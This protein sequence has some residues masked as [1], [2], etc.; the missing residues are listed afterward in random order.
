MEITPTRRTTC[1]ECATGGKLKFLP[2]ADHHLVI[3]VELCAHEHNSVTFIQN[4]VGVT[5]HDC[6]STT[7]L[8]IEGAN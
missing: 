7:L 3:P 4:G 2:C 6:G 8:E 5:C 1:K